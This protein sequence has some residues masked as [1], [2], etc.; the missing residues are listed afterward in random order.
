MRPGGGTVEIALSVHAD[1]DDISRL[2]PTPCQ[3]P[4][5]CGSLA[6]GET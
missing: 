4:S 2:L 1:A 6:S 3:R 5:L